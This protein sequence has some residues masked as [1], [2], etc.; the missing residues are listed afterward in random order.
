MGRAERVKREGGEM[1]GGQL[2]ADE[3]TFSDSKSDSGDRETVESTEISEQELRGI[4]LRQV[5]TTPG[6]FLKVK[7]AYQA[8]RGE[9]D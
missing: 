1:T 2:G 4:W 8:D 7:F 5:Q 3:I 9:A 6:E